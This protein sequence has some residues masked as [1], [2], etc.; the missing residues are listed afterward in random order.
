[1]NN[2][3]KRTWIGGKYFGLGGCSVCSGIIDEVNVLMVLPHATDVGSVPC[4]T[5]MS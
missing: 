4:Q 3:I 1:M 5:Y 2:N